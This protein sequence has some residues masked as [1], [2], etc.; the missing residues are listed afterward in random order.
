MKRLLLS[1]VFTF[2]LF[3][4]WSQ[5]LPL[6][7]R[8]VDLRYTNEKVSI[9]LARM[10]QQ[11]GFSFSYNSSLVPEDQVITL[12]IRQKTVREALNEI[13]KGSATYKEKGNH[14]ILTKV[15]VKQNK[16]ATTSMIISGYVED[17]Q[18]KQRIAE[19]S[20]Y[21][22]KSI[23]STVSDEFGFFRLKLDKKPDEPLEVSISKKDYRDT[24]I[25]LT[26]SGNQY[27]HISLAARKN[28]DT[29]VVVADPIIA[30]TTA[31]PAVTDEEDGEEE[32]ILPYQTA[33]NVQN[34]RDTLYRDFQVSLIPFIGTNA[35]LSGNVINDYSFNI[36]GGYSLGTRQ[37]EVGGF[38]NMDRGDVSWLQLAGFGNI[39]GGNVYGI[40]AAGFLNVNGGETKAVQ[41]SGFGNLNFK[42]FQGVQASGY[43]NINLRAADGVLAAGFANFANGRS[44][45]VQVAGFANVHLGDYDGPQVAGFANVATGRI[46]GSQI[47]GFINYGG[48]VRGTQLGF[49]NVA[50]SLTGVPVGFLSY[51]N[52]GYHKIELS[53]DEVFY[54]NIAFRSGVRQFYNILYAGFKPD[55]AFGNNENVWSFGYG[56]GTARKLSRWLHLN[57][58]VTSHHVNKGSFTPE[59]SSLNKVHVGFDF[60]LLKHFSIYAGATVNGYLTRTTYTDYAQLFTDYSPRVFH[61]DTFRDVNLKMWV[62]GKVALRFL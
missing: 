40:Q 3:A 45:G 15:V 25:T 27:F 24:T 59:L 18:T 55:R 39:V 49:L 28:E 26:E 54:G 37:I 4:S 58:D 56:L 6:L 10:A 9:V 61:E 34:I 5:T 7:D 53:A 11:A 33:P 43:A 16:S 62:G 42:D 23:T 30:D 35:E 19:A 13:F 36:F 32:L 14:I 8:P 60:I 47:S 22:K 21:E 2:C 29:V 38:F 12:D 31:V 44:Q 48:N 17:V 1:C 51:V 46:R 52:H 41:A 57:F 50:D 20:V